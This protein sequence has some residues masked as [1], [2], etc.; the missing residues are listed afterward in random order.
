MK[1]KMVSWNVNGLRAAHKKGFLKTLKKL[2]CDIFCIQE[3]KANPGQLPED[4]VDPGEYRGLFYSAERKG[5]S[6]VA[7]YSRLP[8]LS[9]S[10][11]LNEPRFDTEGRVLTLEY[12]EFFLVNCYVPNAQPDLKRIEYRE[13][14]NDRLKEHLLELEEEKPV[15]L[16]GDLNV[17]HNP[18]DLKNPSRNEQNPGYSIRERRKFTDLLDAGFVDIFRHC[19]PDK[20]SYTWWSYRFWAREKDIGWRID[21]FILSPRLL[22][23]VK[24]TGHHHHVFGSDHCPVFLELGP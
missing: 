9:E 24:D 20:V 23:H 11:G 22:A 21:Y 2:D 6:G 17:A 5:Y 10:R 4:L 13:A 12:P 7:A 15:I 3:T 1:T 19:Y 16:C 8:V 14:F 18:I